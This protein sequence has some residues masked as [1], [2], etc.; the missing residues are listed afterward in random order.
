MDASPIPNK[1]HLADFEI[2]LDEESGKPLQIT[3]PQGQ[4]V[5]VHPTSQKKGFVAAFDPSLCATCPFFEKGQCP[6]QPG[7]RDGRLRLR[8]TQAEAQASQRRRRSQEQKK[9]AGNRR[10]AVEATVRSVK[11]PFP[12][13]KLPVRGL[14]RVTC[15]VIGSAAVTNVRRIQRYLEAKNQ[16]EDLQKATE[17]ER[18]EKQMES[19]AS[20]LCEFSPLLDGR[21]PPGFPGQF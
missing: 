1:L 11:H 12:A 2:K 20:F 18:K 4:K 7:K 5:A 8:F 6:A 16:R 3:C 13:G 21:R 10:A 14:F 17:E 19:L 9:T 15:M